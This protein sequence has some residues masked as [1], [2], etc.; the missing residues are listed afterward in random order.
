MHRQVGIDAN[1]RDFACYVAEIIERLESCHLSDSVRFERS[2]EPKFRPCLDCARHERRRHDQSNPAIT[3]AVSIIRLEK[4]HSL[5]YHDTTRAS[6]P[7]STAVSR[8]STVELAGW[9][10]KSELTSG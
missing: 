6:L 1:Q 10:L 3:L 5:S 8:L 7:S 2:R 9:W 4:P